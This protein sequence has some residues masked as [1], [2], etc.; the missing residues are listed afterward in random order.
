MTSSVSRRT[1]A[2]ALV[3]STISL[4]TSFRARA[5]GGALFNGRVTQADGVTP[6]TGVVV[7]LA[8]LEA[9]RTFRSKPTNE[10][11]SFRIDSAPAGT[12]TLFAEA[13]EGAYLAAS[14]L[15]LK[16]GAN[17]PVQ[18]TLRAGAQPSL[19]PGQLEKKL[20]KYVKLA[21]VGILLVTAWFLFDNISESGASDPIPF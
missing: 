18:L 14:E 5:G 19:A 7:V 9:D 2:L 11:G 8:N 15:A 6:R 3:L 20:P 21:I 4:P 16:E 17:T 13:E 1:V 12:Y 10:E